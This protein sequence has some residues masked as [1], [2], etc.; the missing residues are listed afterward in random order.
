MEMGCLD[1]RQ[2]IEIFFGTEKNAHFYFVG[3]RGYLHKLVAT[4]SVLGKEK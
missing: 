2:Y 1:L 3:K 4:V